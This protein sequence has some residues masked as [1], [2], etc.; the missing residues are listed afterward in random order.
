MMKPFYTCSILQKGETV[1][2]QNFFNFPTMF[3]ILS[4]SNLVISV[5]FDLSSANVFTLDQF[6]KFLSAIGLIYLSREQL[7]ITI[8]TNGTIDQKW[9]IK[10]G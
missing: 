2:N 8:K 7:I 5:T 4:C 6:K 9:T 3:I 10:Q 1:G